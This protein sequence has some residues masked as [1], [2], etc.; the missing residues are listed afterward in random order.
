MPWPGIGASTRIRPGGS[1][2]PSLG[3]WRG[4][5]PLVCDRLRDGNR[6]TSGA[7]T[8]GL[9]GSTPGVGTRRLCPI[10]HEYIELSGKP[11]SS[12][13]NRAGRALAGRLDKQEAVSLVVDTALLLR[14]VASTYFTGTE[15]RSFRTQCEQVMGDTVIPDLLSKA[16]GPPS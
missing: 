15:L 3:R 13:F 5:H 10:D 9:P 2:S 7:Q 14:E 16:Y 1:R 8:T 6:H 12:R 4:P 11:Y